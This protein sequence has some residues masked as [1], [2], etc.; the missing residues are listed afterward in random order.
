MNT[1]G[2][3]YCGAIKYEAEFD[4][5]RVAICHCRDC[6]IFSGSAFR[7]AT[8][9][10][11]AK[12]TITSGAPKFYDKIT[13]SGATRRMAFCGDCGTHICSM[14][15]D[16]TEPGSFISLR[17]SSSQDFAKMNPVAE[18][19]CDSRVSWL[20]L[21]KGATQFPKQPG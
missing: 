9:V 7:I 4:E 16:M 18:I 19:W 17:V 12:F 10:G 2:A 13:D 1:R 14:P 8:R 11:P 6:Q 20:D 5:T 15:L 21:V 3:C